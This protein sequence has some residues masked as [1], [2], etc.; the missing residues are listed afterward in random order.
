MNQTKYVLNSKIW[1]Y[2]LNIPKMN[3]INHESKDE[4]I[5]QKFS[6][7]IKTLNVGSIWV[8]KSLNLIKLWLS[9]HSSPF[10]ILVISK[11][12]QC[13]FFGILQQ[14]TE[15]IIT[16]KIV[17]GGNVASLCLYCISM[18][19]FLDWMLASVSMLWLDC[20]SSWSVLHSCSI[21]DQSCVIME[22]VSSDFPVD[23]GIASFLI[24]LVIPITQQIVFQDP[25]FFSF[26]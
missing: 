7:F 25:H 23:V 2:K 18:P 3:K 10:S 19:F 14:H 6:L 1:F 4:D 16:W 9:F 24:F 5:I 21:C 8:K 13:T 17:Y 11:V 20:E 26:S 22:G 15:V 12:A